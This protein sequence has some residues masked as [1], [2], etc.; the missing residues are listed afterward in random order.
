MKVLVIGKGGREHAIVWK[1][2][3]S[4]RISQLLCAP[5]NAG[6]ARIASNVPISETDID[7]LLTFVTQHGID[8]TVVGPGS[9]PRGGNRR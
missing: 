6:T 2:S 9:S 5:G 4:A 7:G 1:L 8:F 3:Q